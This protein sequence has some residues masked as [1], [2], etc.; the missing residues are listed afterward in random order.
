MTAEAKERE[1]HRKHAG[2]HTRAAQ[3]NEDRDRMERRRQQQDSRSGRGNLG[4]KEGISA[5]AN[6]DDAVGAM[7]AMVL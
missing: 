2:D 4:D 3:K 1:A 6:Q 5:E 7:A